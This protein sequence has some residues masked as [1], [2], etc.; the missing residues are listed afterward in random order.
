MASPGPPPPDRALHARN[1]GLVSRIKASGSIPTPFWTYVYYHGEKWKAYGEDKLRSMFAHRWFLDAGIRVP[2]ASDYSPGP[3]EPM[4]ALQSMVTR[5]DYAGR[6]WGTNQ[7][8]SIDEALQIATINGAYASY[9]ENVKG[10]SPSGKYADF[11]ILGQNPRT[12]DANRLKDVPIVR[13]V[14]AGKTM[15]SQA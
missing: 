1:P 10:P 9:E 3:F 7:R 11:V 2:G 15:Y 12:I 13:T 14:V 8:V 6:E 4:M 5:T